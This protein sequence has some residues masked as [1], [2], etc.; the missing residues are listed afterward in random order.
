MITGY[1]RIPIGG[2]AALGEEDLGGGLGILLGVERVIEGA[3]DAGMIC[4]VDLEAAYIDVG[5]AA[6]HDREDSGYGIA[7]GLVVGAASGGIDRPWPG[8][9]TGATGA[10]TLNSADGGQDPRRYV[11]VPLGLGSSQIA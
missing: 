10:T 7:L 6:N 5:K 3:E 9:P 1:R 11:P 2:A 8:G 4:D